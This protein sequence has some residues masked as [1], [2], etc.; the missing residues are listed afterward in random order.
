MISIT[1]KRIAAILLAIVLV[2][3]GIIILDTPEISA[4]TSVRIGQATSDEYGN[5]RGG[6]AG[7]QTGGEVATAKWSY[8]SKNGNYNNWKY[9]IRAIDPAVAS[10]L[11]DCMKKACANDHIGYDQ[12]YPDRCSCYDEAKAV[13]WQIDK[14]QK[15][16]ETT[17]AQIVS[18]CLNAV[19]IK[20]GRYWDSSQ[21][22]D[23]LKATGKFS[24][25][26]SSE[27]TASSSLLEAGDILVSPGVHTV[28][29]IE[30]PNTPGST[31]GYSFISNFKAGKDYQLTDSLYVRTGP[32]S[33]FPAKT[34]SQVTTGAK[35]YTYTWEGKARLRKGTVVT[36]LKSQGEWVCIP[37][38]WIRGKNGA[39]VHLEEYKDTAT[40]KA[41]YA[42]ARGTSSTTAAAGETIGDKRLAI[43]VG[44]NYYLAKT[45]N[46][47]TGPGLTYKNVKRKNLTKDGKKH[48]TKSSAAKLRK[49]TEVTCL[50]VRGNWMRIPSGWICCKPGN[51]TQD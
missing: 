40:Q 38:G 26:T 25:L 22:V 30:S 34:Y 47:R 1:G 4:A 36:C 33:I 51:I 46:V 17:C 21:V 49:G 18:V 2:F 43:I 8:S 13:D 41:L 31:I 11:A 32:G 50:E 16:C 35:P 10:R 19:G 28:M 37:S 20:V 12:S 42:K 15:D 6:K 24:I 27:F 45:L 23:D 7:D 48:A 3:T 44:E 39:V 9:V 14:I 29:V 5:I